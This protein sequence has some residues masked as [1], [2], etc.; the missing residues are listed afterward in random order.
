MKKER[1]RVILAVCILIV[2]AS[3]SFILFS[4]LDKKVTG[5]IL[6]KDFIFK[7]LMGH[8]SIDFGGL[9][10]LINVSSPEN[11]TY[12]FN[13]GDNY[14]LDLNVSSNFNVDS[15]WYTLIDLKHNSIVNETVFFT[16]NTTFNAVRWSNQIRVYA[17]DSSGNEENSN[18]TFFIYVPNSAPIIHDIPN[19]IYVC[20]NDYLSYYF[21]V[22]DIDEDRLYSDIVPKDPFYIYPSSS[23][24]DP[25]ASFEIFSSSLSKAEAGGVDNGWQVYQE[26]VSISDEY[27]ATCCVDTKQTNITVIEVNNAPDIENIG[28]KTVWT[29]GDNSTFFKEVQVDDTE[30]GNQASGNL[31]FNLTI[32]N[33]TGQEVEIFNISQFGIMNYT[34]NISHIGVYNISVCVNDTGI[35]NPHSGIL[36]NCSQTGGSIFSCDDFSLTV[37]DENRAPTIIENYP[38]NLSLSILGTDR[39]FFNVTNYDPDGTVPDTYWYVDNSFE[40]YDSGNLTE[41]FD[42]SFGCGVQGLHTVKVEITDGLLNDSIEWTFD[43][44]LVSCPSP[45]KGGAGGGGGGGGVSVCTEKWVCGD[46]K[47]CQNAKKSLE[48]GSLTGADYRKIEQLCGS[49]GWGEKYCGVQFRNCH[50]SNLCNKTLSKPEEV[51]T[52][53]FVSQPS[54]SDGIKNC[55]DGSCELL[56]DCGGPCSPCP[57]CSDNIQNQGEEGIDCGGPCPWE[58]PVEKPLI[59]KSRFKYFLI[60]IILA[61]AILTVIIIKLRR[62]YTL[63][64]E[65]KDLR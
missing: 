40:Q 11:K 45:P 57:T 12:Y 8:V 20:E 19:D 63:K 51:R 38:S 13:K 3:L 10:N 35:A 33:S 31:Y 44:Q 15:W 25:N 16:P 23:L 4:S 5:F 36:G 9:E 32:L 56:I 26:T 64:K 2:V 55:H 21:N 7:S 6:F 22:T 59:E 54:C 42:Y 39:I 58:C 37:T 27:N 24:T 50:D 48:K 34:S 43:V 61:L 1:K 60:F 41:V 62:I 29:T 52:C 46:W 49:K 18:V 53:Y 47:V 65:I 17:N 28:V 30:D 14:T